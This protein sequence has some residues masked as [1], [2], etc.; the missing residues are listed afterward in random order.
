LTVG[1]GLPNPGETSVPTPSQ[2]GY[3]ETLVAVAGGYP[4]V[5]VDD[6]TTWTSPSLGAGVSTPPLNSSGIVF[7][8]WLN[9]NL[10]FADGTNWRYYNRSANEVRVWAAT[11][12]A[13]PEDD[14]GNLPRLIESH[15]GR[16]WLSGLLMD[17]HNFALSRVL[18]GFDFDYAPESPD[19]QQAIFA[20]T[21]AVGQPGD[22]IHA[23]CS[24]R[25]DLF[26]VGCRRSIYQIVGDPAAG[27]RMTKVTDGIG[28]AWGR[29]YA[30]SFDG[31]LWFFGHEPGVYSLT[32]GTAPVFRSQAV[33]K[34]IRDLDM[35]QTKVSVG[36]S[37]R[38]RELHVFLT[39]LVAP[40]ASTHLCFETQ[41]G[42]WWVDRFA[43]PGHDPLCVTTFRGDLALGCWDGHV[44]KLDRSATTDDGESISSTVVIGP[45]LSRTMDD[46]MLQEIQAAFGANSGSVTYQV[47]AGETPEVALAAPAKYTNTWAAGRNV[48]DLPMHSGHAV[49]LKLTS[50]NRWA[51]EQVRMITRALGA[52][53]R[54]GY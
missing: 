31:T 41:T 45:I 15:G 44:R 16:L 38:R 30:T 47:L 51:Y 35:A 32:P 3:P 52:G 12:G 40:A 18:D 36:W 28:M 6:D 11:A 13:L 21:G 20:A 26:L 29:P 9:G 7:G 27:G 14:D 34:Y 49:Y 1:L 23:G 50:T 25:D 19:D 33:Q 2:S 8:A 43:D 46:M 53:R 22:V 39:P 5:T 37:R 24:Y 54:K 4:F 17:P 48:A 42:A 10:H